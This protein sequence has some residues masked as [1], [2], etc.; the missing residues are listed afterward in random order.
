MTEVLYTAKGK[1]IADVIELFCL[2]CPSKLILFKNKLPYCPYCKKLVYGGRRH[3]K[4][5]CL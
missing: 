2:F 4:K 3:I 5:R 1:I